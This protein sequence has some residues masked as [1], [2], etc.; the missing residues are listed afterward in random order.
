MVKKRPRP[1]FA[2]RS[3]GNQLS[4]KTEPEYW[5]DRLF[6]N[7][8][9]YQGR[10]QRV[11]HWSVKI[12]HLGTRKTFALRAI[13]EKQAANEACAIYKKIVTHGWKSVMADLE[14]PEQRKAAGP[15]ATQSSGSNA[16]YWLPRLI[17]RKYTESLHL[18]ANREL[19]V[20]IDY[21]DASHYFPLGT[22]D[23]RVAANKA[24]RI[25]KVI[26]AHG[27][28]AACELFPRELSVAIRWADNPLAWTYT[29][30]HTQTAIRRP[31]SETVLTGAGSRLRVAIAESDAGLRQ[32]LAWCINQQE[33]CACTASF[34]TAAAALREIPRLPPHLLLISQNL[35]DK[36]GSACLKEL[37]S[38]SLKVT[39]L[40]F[41]VYE[42]SDQLF[43][44]APGGAPYYL[45]RRT[46]PTRI[47]APIVGVGRNGLLTREE[48]LIS[49]RRF[50][51]NA[52][53]SLPVGGPTNELSSLTQRE[54]EILALL[55]KG[56]PDKEI[57]DSL[58]ISTWTV[59][60]HLKKIFE[61]LGAH[62]RTDAVVKYLNK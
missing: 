3:N 28:A 26:A 42:D 25:Y 10:Q 62:N 19:S 14:V 18:K 31:T 36:S 15:T 24:A 34:G 8:F 40:L 32:A 17:H 12:Q 5:R 56:H 61:K 16:S 53:S 44:S 58:R 39:G 54:H 48:I 35:A 41:S 1:R 47:L 45:L 49:V 29:T 50:F 51:E 59:H 33:G 6:R 46:P 20:R 4:S 37:D 9:T 11:K 60:G 43:K 27:W 52:I 7:S 30:I 2:P 21:G 38:T 13:D 57:A 22:D 23:Q 55:S